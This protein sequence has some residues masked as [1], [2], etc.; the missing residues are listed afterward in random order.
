MPN[1]ISSTTNSSASRGT[2]LLVGA[3][4]AGL[5]AARSLLDA[6]FGVKVLEKARGVGG[7][8]ATR[9][10]GDAVFD[11]GAQFVTAR[12]TRFQSYIDMWQREG[13]V[14]HWTNGFASNRERKKSGSH[15]RYRA[16]PGM[17]AI[18]KALS[19]GVDV[20][21]NTPVR[22]VTVRS[23]RW[24]AISETKGSFEGE[25]L[26]LTPPVPQSLRLLESGGITLSQDA[27]KDLRQIHYHSCIALMLIF[28]E[29]SAIPRPGAIQFEGSP[30]R[31]MADNQQ[32]GISLHK[33]AVTI[34]AAPEF[35]S[36]HWTATDEEVLERLI[37]VAAPWL[38]EK[39]QQYQVHRWLYSQPVDLGR[40]ENITLPGSPPLLFA[41]DAF[42]GGRV[43]GAALSGLRAADWLI[44]NS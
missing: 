17:T 25:A 21:L 39:V 33:P 12:D 3:G 36:E 27:G 20:E 2:C 10:F 29:P 23:G 26:I 18:P 5:M 22:S 38:P 35:S 44:A 28:D 16:H 37:H 13:I 4:I 43:E 7:R 8:M 41:G 42:A 19:A 15:S 6:G 9:R 1:T 32:K 24:H 34:H 11:H 31:W 40:C 14:E 30:I